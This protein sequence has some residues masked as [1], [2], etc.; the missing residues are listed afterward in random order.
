MTYEV[1][2][3]VFLEC[4]NRYQTSKTAG[5][6]VLMTGSIAYLTFWSLTT[7]QESDAGRPPQSPW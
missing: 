7:H 1:A 6:A 5:M 4:T 2:Q 3:R